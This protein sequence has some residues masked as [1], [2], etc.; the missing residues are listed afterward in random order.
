MTRF[1]GWLSGGGGLIMLLGVVAFFGGVYEA[2][3]LYTSPSIAP[4][5]SSAPI[6]VVAVAVVVLIESVYLGYL[7][8]RV[9][10]LSKKQP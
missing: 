5:F 9:E 8:I 4:G 6:V 2:Y 10:R 3:S 7:G 1:M